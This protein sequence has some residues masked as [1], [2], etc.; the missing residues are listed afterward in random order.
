MKINSFIP[1]E[2][3][4]YIYLLLSSVTMLTVFGHT[5]LLFYDNVSFNVE[6][7]HS[8]FHADIASTNKGRQINIS[9]LT[10]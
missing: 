10:A 7:Q 2:R 9:H 1:Q 5:P 8:N 6:V 3:L 4:V